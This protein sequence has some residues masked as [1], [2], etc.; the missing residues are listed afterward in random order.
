MN[1]NNNTYKYI[2]FNLWVQEIKYFIF[3]QKKVREL[4]K[5]NIKT[6][7]NAIVEYL[8]YQLP[9]TQREREICKQQ[10][11]IKMRHLPAVDRSKRYGR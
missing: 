10:S 8:D 2:I 7:K 3:S 11:E 5:A 6:R 9:V 1:M 4:N